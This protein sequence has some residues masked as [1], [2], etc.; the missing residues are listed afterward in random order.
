MT[1]HHASRV[2]AALRLQAQS[3]A[4]LAD[5]IEAGDS[6]D[7]DADPW[8][9]VCEH[10]PL[11]KRVTMVAAR[12]GAIDGAVKRGRTWVARCSALDTWL[13]REGP[14]RASNDVSYLDRWRRR[15]AGGS[16]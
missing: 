1:A 6:A 10:S 11:S 9:D 3:L 5:A 4:A 2:A 15:A 7:H 16:K 12:S 13:T 14:D 8:V